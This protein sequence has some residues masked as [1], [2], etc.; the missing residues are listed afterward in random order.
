MKELLSEDCKIYHTSELSKV[1]WERLS[2]HSQ[3]FERHI[4]MLKNKIIIESTNWEDRLILLDLCRE[5]FNDLWYF[6]K[7][8]ESGYS[9]QIS[10]TIYAL[11]KDELLKLKLA[12]RKP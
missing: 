7:K 11:D 6:E 12:L 10:I 4:I 1:N 2:E 9:Q 8:S 5:N 3:W